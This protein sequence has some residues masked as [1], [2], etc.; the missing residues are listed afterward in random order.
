MVR[1]YAP[2]D[3]TRAPEMEKALAL[4]TELIS[5]LQMTDVLLISTVMY[6]FSGPAVLKSWI[7][8]VIRQGFYTLS[9]PR[10]AGDAGKQES[11]TDR[12]FEGLLR[13]S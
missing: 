9:C 12:G 4:S 10:L 1:V 2:A 11:P 13:F 5:E 6:N 8:Y 3:A 7:D